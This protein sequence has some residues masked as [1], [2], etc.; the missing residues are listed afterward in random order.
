MKP[1]KS[2]G[3]DNIPAYIYKGLAEFLIA[4]SYIFNL[5]LHKNKFPKQL[6]SAVITPT[7]KTGKINDLCNYRPRKTGRVLKYRVGKCME[8]RC[9]G[10]I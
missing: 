8:S 10:I 4:I 7:H 2:T 6:Q 1:K 3:I 9:V 5:A